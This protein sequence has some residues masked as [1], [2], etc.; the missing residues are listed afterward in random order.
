MFSEFLTQS[1]MS[2][3]SLMTLA[4]RKGWYKPYQNPEEQVSTAYQ[5]ASG[6]FTQEMRTQ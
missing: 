4:I 6:A 1:V 3:E 5:Q 2:Q